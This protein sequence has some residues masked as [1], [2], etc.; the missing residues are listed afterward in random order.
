MNHPNSSKRPSEPTSLAERWTRMWND[1]L[2]A[3][4]VVAPDCSTYFGRKPVTPRP[5]SAHGPAELQA[6]VDAIRK[7]IP[8]VRYGHR[9]EPLIARDGGETIT[10]LWEVEAPGVG[11]R[12]GIDVLRHRD[13]LITEVWSVTG[14]LELPPMR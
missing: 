6:A 10:L 5:E 7:A 8:G 4:A 1:E 2:P 13:G 12:S 9:S 3:A 11:R 14:D